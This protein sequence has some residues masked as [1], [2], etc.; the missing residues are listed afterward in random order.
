MQ[1]RAVAV[2]RIRLGVGELLNLR[3]GDQDDR[4]FPLVAQ[5]V[6]PLQDL[7]P[8][9]QRERVA[10]PVRDV[11][12]RLDAVFLADPR[13]DDRLQ[14]VERIDH[15]RAVV[16]GLTVQRAHRMQDVCVVLGEREPLAVDVVQPFFGLNED[17]GIGHRA[18][19]ALADAVQA[20][21]QHAAW[22][23]AS[24]CLNLIQ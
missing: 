4:H 24:A 21:N 14:P 16:V 23:Y 12:D 7:P 19:G 5:R 20:V 2:V 6:E 3:V 8:E 9:R 17:W 18:E 22:S 11:L 15:Q 13:E 1:A 10:L